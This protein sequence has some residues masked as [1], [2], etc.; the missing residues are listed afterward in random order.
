MQIPKITPQTLVVYHVG[1]DAGL[2]PVAAVFDAAPD[3]VLVTFEVRGDADKLFV[4]RDQLHAGQTRIKVNRAVDQGSATREFYVTN[5]PMSSSLFKASPMARSEDPGYDHCQTWEQNTEIVKTLT[6]ETS[7][8]EEIIREFNLPPPDIIS[9]DAQ[10]AELAILKGAGR[11]LRE[12]TLAVMTEVEFSEIY[13]RQP[14]FDDQMAHLSADGF[15]LVTLYNAQVWH[16]LARMGI[17]G[18]LTA[19]EA[20]FFKYFHAFDDGEEHPSLGYMDMRQVPTPTL[21]KMCIISMGF[22]MISYAIK[23]AKFVKAERADYHEMVA[24]DNMLQQVFYA[25]D[26]FEK[27]QFDEDRSLN[28]FHD[29]LKFGGSVF[30]RYPVVDTCLMRREE[31]RLAEEAKK[32]D[33]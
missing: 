33:T 22:R 10:G 14:L 27:H 31:K 13:H 23:I 7:S 8:L 2:G 9:I 19:A 12:N 21:L 6:V 20:L 16:P 30:L 3:S 1:G 15:R 17:T 24:A 28:Y 4:D 29:T 25:L 18:F 26:H 11:Y 5:E 32:S